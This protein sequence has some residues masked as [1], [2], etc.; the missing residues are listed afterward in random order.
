M[1]YIDLNKAIQI[2]EKS[3]NTISKLEKWKGHLYNWYNTKTLAPLYPRYVS[4]VDN[5]NLIGYIFTL[6]QFLI[7]VLQNEP[8]NS[9]NYN[10]AQKILTQCE[11]LINNTNFMDLYDKEKGIFSIGFNVE[12]NKLTDSY[13]DL[14]ASEARQASLIA[15]A[16]KD[17]PAKHWNN[18][19]RTLTSLNGYKGL[20]SWS[21]TAFEYLMP[22]INIKKYPGSL[23]DESCKFLIMSQQEYSQKLGI[24]WGISESA[25]N[26]K[27]LNS[28]YQYKAFGIP[29]LGLKRGLG[30]EKIITP[31]A[32]SMALTEVP[33][34][35]IYNLQQIKNEGM[36]GKYGLYE[37]LD[38]TPERVSTKLKKAPVKTYMAHHQGLILLSINNLVN[39][40][41]L[42]KRFMYNPE[43]EAVDILLQE[44]MPINVITTKENKEKIEKIKY[45]DFE[46]YTE[47][48][49]TDIN[50]N[51]TNSNVISNDEYTVC[52]NDKGEGVS[53]YKNIIINK[54]KETDDYSQGIFFYV[55]NV[56][57]Q[58]TWNVTKPNNT[59][60]EIHFMPDTCKFI[61]KHD[62]LETT[63]KVVISPDEPVEIRSL[64]IQNNGEEEE[65]L[66]ITSVVEPVLSSKEQ[67][68]AHPAFNKLFLNTEYLCETGSILVKRKSRG[69]SSDMYLG[70]NLYTEN[71][72]IGDLEYEVD[73]A[74]L[75]G[76][77]NSG[78]PQMIENSAPFSRNLG[79]VPDL[80]VALKRT[81]KIKP[82]RK[83]KHKSPNCSVRSKRKNR[84]KYS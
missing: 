80:D 11:E 55:K 56:K 50:E 13:Y 40:N 71:E 75:L 84:R 63:L 1:G 7:R 10:S 66:E 16:K 48:V 22:N 83:N 20:I 47:R 82:R 39:N 49:Y 68:Y 60:Q 17:V 81:M 62:N 46:P 69:E 53:S 35:V 67:D 65:I 52:I 12:E 45:I 19:S 58:K 57:T 41:V 34:E 38:Y 73:R 15:I 74:K 23:L 31:Y 25:F 77:G 29:W 64:Q 27:D 54:Y 61:S 51:I 70:L 32:S 5:G 9:D 30:D 37:A 78:I 21:G 6:K 79:I 59:K 33:K 44:R 4:T 36:E 43:I 8:E 72:T 76:R 3:V 2:L 26:L 18:L 42:Q 14:L 28:N 24:P